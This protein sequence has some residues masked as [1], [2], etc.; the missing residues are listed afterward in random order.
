MI[1]KKGDYLLAVKENQKGL[2]EATEELFR[3]SSTREKNKLPQSE[4]A[5]KKENVHG[6]DESRC[7]RVLYL[8]KEV[9]FFPKE[10]W[11]EAHA[12]IR[13][14]SERKIRSTAVT[15]TQTRYYI[16]STKKSAK[17]L[18]EKVRDHVENKLHGSLDVT[19]NE[20]G[21]KKWAEESAKNCSLL[22]QMALNLLKKEPTKKS[23]RRKQKMAAMDN[24]YLMKILF[25]DPL[26][27]SYA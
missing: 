8:E 4:H 25:A 21:D 27:K 9:S 19:M 13:I 6:R 14:R 10:D 2:Y 24:S 18:N 22:R 20:D 23:I 11:P 26:P 15:S 3:R 5:E 16:C 1:E 7:C 17:E 12:L